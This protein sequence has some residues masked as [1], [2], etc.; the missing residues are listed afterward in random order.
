MAYSML[1]YRSTVRV[2]SVYGAN[3]NPFIY[4]HEIL[5]GCNRNRIEIDCHDKCTHV[6]RV[7]LDTW[8]R[9]VLCQENGIDCSPICGALKPLNP[10]SDELSKPNLNDSR[11]TVN[12]IYP[13]HLQSPSYKLISKRKQEKIICQRRYSRILNTFLEELF[14][15]CK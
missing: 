7:G 8:G 2:A 13:M 15:R 11:L 6:L 10:L 5:R 1:T 4:V 14:T 9:G 3:G 12:C